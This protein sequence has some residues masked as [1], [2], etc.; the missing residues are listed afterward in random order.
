MDKKLPHLQSLE[1]LGGWI[2]LYCSTMIVDPDGELS[3]NY[4]DH[5]R[6]RDSEP[7]SKMAIPLEAWASI[8]NHS[9]RI[10]FGIIG[11]ISIASLVISSRLIIDESTRAN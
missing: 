7:E 5:K 9:F 8:R 1:D 4:S 3:H 2:G 10:F 6:L 11:L